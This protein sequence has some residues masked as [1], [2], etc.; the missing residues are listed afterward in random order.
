[1][2]ASSSSASD[3]VPVTIPEGFTLHTE[4]SARILLPATDEAFLNPVQEFNRDMSVAC[5]R[6]WSEELSAGKE[7]KWREKM[8][9]A[10]SRG[11]DGKGKKK[12]KSELLCIMRRKEY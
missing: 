10:A 1:M 2:A 6:V 5:I 12:L 7:R 3:G 4:N 9:K 8:E 11:A